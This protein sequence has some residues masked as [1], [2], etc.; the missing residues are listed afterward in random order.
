MLKGCGTYMLL[1][2]TTAVKEEVVPPL[3]PLCAPNALTLALALAL[4]LDHWWF[5]TGTT[6]QAHHKKIP[7]HKFKDYH[8]EDQGRKEE[9][10]RGKEAGLLLEMGLDTNPTS[11]KSRMVI[12]QTDRST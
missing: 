12:G 3:P 9:G 6:N 10:G 8:S 1:L 4:W 5:N 11:F 2:C 7:K